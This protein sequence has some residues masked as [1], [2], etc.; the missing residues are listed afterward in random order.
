MLPKLS[1]MLLILKTEKEPTLYMTWMQENICATGF[2]CFK[3][4]N[5][6][7]SQR[8]ITLLAAIPKSITILATLLAEAE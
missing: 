6:H 4:D 8:S 3:S 1:V 5:M 7:T 2:S